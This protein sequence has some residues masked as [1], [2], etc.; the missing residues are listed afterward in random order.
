M[1]PYNNTFIKYELWCS[2]I[3]KYNEYNL[4]LNKFNEKLLNAYIFTHINFPLANKYLDI[5]TMTHVYVVI[6]L[7]ADINGRHHIRYLI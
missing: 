4:L 3:I 1:I 7:H 6:F 2:K 5:P